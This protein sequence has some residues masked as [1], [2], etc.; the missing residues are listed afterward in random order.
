MCSV[1]KQFSFD[2]RLCNKRICA[3]SEQTRN[4]N[5][6]QRGGGGEERKETLADKPRDFESRPLGLSCL[7]LPLPPLSFFGSRFISRAAKT[8]N[9]VP[10][11][12]FALK[13]NGNACYA[14]YV[15]R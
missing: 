13:P 9:S 14:G 8:E 12:L 6:G 1:F 2:C 5:Q 4:E 11:S 7:P 3:F 15:D 10:L